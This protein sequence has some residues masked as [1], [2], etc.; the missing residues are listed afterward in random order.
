M[1]CTF[2]KITALMLAGMMI[3]NAGINDNSVAIA[4]QITQEDDWGEELELDDLS[5]LIDD[6]RENV[7]T[8]G[9][10]YYKGD[11]LYISTTKLDDFT[12]Y[13]ESLASAF[14]SDSVST[15]SDQ[16]DSQNP[17]II[18]E[19]VKYSYQELLEAQKTVNEMSSEIGSYYNYVNEFDNCLVIGSEYEL[20][21]ETKNLLAQTLQMD[22]LQYE[23]TPDDYADDVTYAV[24]G[25]QIV[26]STANSGYSLGAAV[27]WK[28]TNFAGEEVTYR[29]W[30]TSGHGTAV[31]D[32]FKYNGS[33]MGKVVR[34][35]YADAL[36]S[37]LILRDDESTVGGSTKLHGT[38]LS[39][40]VYNSPKSGQIVTMY[41]ST[42]GTTSGAIQTISF[43]RTING[44]QFN[45]LIQAQYTSLP[46]DSG[47]PLIQ[48]RKNDG[49][50]LVGINKGHY[51]FSGA[52]C[53]LGVNIF[54]ICDTYGVTVTSK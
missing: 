43:S 14:Y 21:D 7:D 52:Y 54:S 33:V 39:F 5:L 11:T 26:N 41:G 38:D 19:E 17:K 36:D 24:N 6:C 12:A 4:A 53:C 1:K 13:S 37:C 23:V 40:S 45:N 22:N 8:F 44:V 10:A 51:T 47:A 28:S 30:I 2:K 42:S 29:G 3:V 32:V 9:G 48:D 35:D 15:Y 18:F 20:S 34:R 46:G 27:K 25:D 31:G 16:A 49:L 50:T